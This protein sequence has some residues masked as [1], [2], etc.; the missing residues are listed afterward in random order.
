MILM[1]NCRVHQDIQS[2]PFSRTD[3][4]NRYSKHLRQAV[5]VDLHSP[6]FHDIH[7]IQRKHHRFAKL[8]Q[9]KR[10]VEIPLQR[11]GIRNV[12]DHI[13]RVAQYV[14]PG[15]L[16]FHCIGCQAVGT[17]KIHQFH[18]V[19]LKPEGAFHLFHRHPRPVCHFQIRAGVRVEQCG[20]STIGIAD[21]RYIQKF[22]T[23]RPAPLLLLYFLSAS[24][25]PQIWFR[26]SSRS[27]PRDVS[28]S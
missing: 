28:G 20:L 24:C 11:R 1:V 25:P 12:N 5:Q 27:S 9:L 14:F 2:P 13:H 10:Q 19:I 6:L 17:R 4:N 3:R 23:H 7:H 18:L 15:N 26:G 21:K 22:I 8:D 16:F